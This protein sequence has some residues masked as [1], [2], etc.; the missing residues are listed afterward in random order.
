MTSG[1][2]AT[3]AADAVPGSP[4][5]AGVVLD[6]ATGET[7]GTIGFF[8]MMIFVFGIRTFLGFG[9]DCVSVFVGVFRANLLCGD[10][11]LVWADHRP[12]WADDRLVWADDRL[13]W[14]DDRLVW[15]DHRPAWADQRPAWADH[16]PAWADQRCRM[17]KTWGTSSLDRETA[18]HRRAARPTSRPLIHFR[19]TTRRDSEAVASFS[20]RACRFV[21]GR[22]RD[23]LPRRRNP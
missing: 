19:G 4:T 1:K 20:S 5:V 12:A 17:A 2:T 13:V 3:V 11:R 9:W 6:V 21:R 7:G 10:E 16:R 22:C 18:R 15:A 14:A 23:A 8:V